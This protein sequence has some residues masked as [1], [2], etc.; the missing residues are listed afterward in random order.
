MQHIPKYVPLCRRIIEY[1]MTHTP[2]SLSGR[3]RAVPLDILFGFKGLALTTAGSVLVA[4]CAGALET[5]PSS[6]SQH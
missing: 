3:H 1:D 5:Q 2:V 4:C 6:D